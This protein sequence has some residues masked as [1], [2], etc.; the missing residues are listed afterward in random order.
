[1]AG[2]VP[3]HISQGRGPLGKRGDVGLRVRP[4][5][6]LSPE[7]VVLETT[8]GLIMVC[9]GYRHYLWPVL[10]VFCQWLVGMKWCCGLWLS[11]LYAPANTSVR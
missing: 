9:T 7:Q 6:T 3:H 11:M 2:A 8:V 1:M 10:V 4:L 5:S